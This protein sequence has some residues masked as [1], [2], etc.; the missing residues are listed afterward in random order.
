M[1]HNRAFSFLLRDI[2]RSNRAALHSKTTYEALNV[3]TQSATMGS[4]F[5]WSHTIREIHVFDGAGTARRKTQHIHLCEYTNRPSSLPLR[6]PPRQPN[7]LAFA[8]VPSTFGRFP[9]GTPAPLARNDKRGAMATRYV[10]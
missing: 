1:L 6:P 2:S 3:I 9:I 5:Q 10:S 4:C 7:T 8:L